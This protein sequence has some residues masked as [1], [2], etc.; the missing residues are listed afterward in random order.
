[1]FCSKTFLLAQLTPQ[2]TTSNYIATCNLIAAQ[3]LKNNEANKS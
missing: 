3:N 1:M 2:H